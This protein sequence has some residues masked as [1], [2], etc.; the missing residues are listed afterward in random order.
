MAATGMSAAAAIPDPPNPDGD[1]YS[2]VQRHLVPL[3]TP[4]VALRGQ[5][6]LGYGDR[7][8]H[9][10][11]EIIKEPGRPRP[12]GQPHRPLMDHQ[13]PN[14]R[15]RQPRTPLLANRLADAGEFKIS[16]NHPEYCGPAE[17]AMPLP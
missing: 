12:I 2:E 3:D 5:R 1:G 16:G 11:A 7:L 6:L 4:D 8:R 17:P 10:E 15:V 9:K 14:V 13:A